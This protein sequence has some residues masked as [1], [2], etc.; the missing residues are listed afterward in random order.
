MMFLQSHPGN[1]LASILMKHKH[2]SGCI[3]EFIRAD[4]ISIISEVSWAQLSG[5][6]HL[7]N[8]SALVKTRS[9]VLFSRNTTA[10]PKLK[11]I[12]P[13][14]LATHAQLLYCDAMSLPEP[15]F[16]S[17]SM[18]AGIINFEHLNQ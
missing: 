13:D 16:Y 14:L 12:Y 1:F 9:C 15:A 11:K 17:E 3:W 7:I 8:R 2:V 18:S 6:L 5:I 10:Q 4:D